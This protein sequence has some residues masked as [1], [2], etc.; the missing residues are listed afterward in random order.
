MHGGAFISTSLGQFADLIKKNPRN[1]CSP[2]D[3]VI[4]ITKVTQEGVSDVKGSKLSGSK[5][6]QNDTKTR[7]FFRKCDDE[8]KKNEWRGWRKTGKSLSRL[9]VP[10]CLISSNEVAR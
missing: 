9:P 3:D 4:K 10:L 5:N 1:D 2:R 8:E 6:S 7:D